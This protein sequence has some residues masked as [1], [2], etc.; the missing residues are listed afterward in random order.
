MCVSHSTETGEANRVL[1]P[2]RGAPFPLASGIRIPL[3]GEGPG[4]QRCGPDPALFVVSTSLLSTSPLSPTPDSSGV[5][6]AADQLERGLEASWAAFPQVS[7]DSAWQ[8][9]KGLFGPASFCPLI[10]LVSSK[11]Q[12]SQ[13]ITAH[14]T[15][16]SASWDSEERTG[17]RLPFLP[18][19]GHRW[20]S[21]AG[22]LHSRISGY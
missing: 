12:S 22:E 14:C 13:A 11:N 4:A 8:S 19:W 16:T 3:R 10:G 15:L 21:V 2:P 5:C 7:C 17:T 6:A 9:P 18:V 1:C 20:S